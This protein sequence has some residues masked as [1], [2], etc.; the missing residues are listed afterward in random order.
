MHK[1]GF[2]I[3]HIA[4]VR[5]ARKA[6]EPDP[7]FA[8]LIAEQA[9][10]SNITLHIREDRRHAQD[11]DLELMTK[12]I[13]I[14]V[15][16]EMAATDDLKHVALAN[17]PGSCTLV[18]EK[19]ME[20]TTEGGLNLLAPEQR[21]LAPYIAE[22]KR[23]GIEVSLFIDPDEAQ[24]DKA[25]VLGADAVEFNTGRY[26]E[27][28]NEEETGRE[29]E[30]IRRAVDFALSSGLKAHCGHGLNYRNVQPLAALGTIEEFNI[31]HSIV[32]R[33]VFVGVEQAI[34]DMLALLRS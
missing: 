30:R 7:V 33:S 12:L 6:A 23:A 14:K 16:L 3:D 28:P 15:N 21:D 8:A 34:K 25:A 1:L 20:L 29:L 4:T 18:P 9:G 17:H 2:N 27:A 26:A 19:R 11:R 24:V 22:L 5:Q 31:G 32:A 10:A 13:K